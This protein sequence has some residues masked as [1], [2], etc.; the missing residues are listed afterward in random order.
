VGSN[1]EWV[2]SATATKFAVLR[3]KLPPKKSHVASFV[4]TVVQLSMKSLARRENA[5]GCDDVGL[6]PLWTCLVQNVAANEH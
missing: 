1:A 4:A 2:K 3:W 5:N 6:K